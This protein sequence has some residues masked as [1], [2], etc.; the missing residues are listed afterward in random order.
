M[1]D[2]MTAA[3]AG[4]PIDQRRRVDREDIG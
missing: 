1:A 2:Q 3:I 4:D